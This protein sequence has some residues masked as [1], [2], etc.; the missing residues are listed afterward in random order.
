L[1]GGAGVRPSRAGSGV[2]QVQLEA[3]Q[4]LGSGGVRRSAKKRGELAHGADVALP[5]VLSELAHAHVVE[6]AL[7][8]RRDGR[9][10]GRSVDVHDP[11]PVGDRGRLD[12]QHRRVTGAMNHH[13]L[14][15]SAYRE[16]FSPPTQTGSTSR[17]SGNCKADIDELRVQDAF[18]P[19]RQ[20]DGTPPNAQSRRSAGAS[21]TIAAQRS[22]PDATT[23]VVRSMMRRFVASNS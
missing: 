20:H 6:H 5:R 2:H 12:H 10:W 17:S 18:E 11:A 8:Q 4:V 9:G 3:A 14:G 7:A 23:L 16:R 1:S 13:Q 22:L 15:R 21:G 19:A